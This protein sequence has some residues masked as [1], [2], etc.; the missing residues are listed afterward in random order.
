MYKI[1]Y[2]VLI[3][4]PLHMLFAEDFDLFTPEEK[5]DPGIYNNLKHHKFRA[6]YCAYPR[7]NERTGIGYEYFFTKKWALFTEGL[8]K[9]SITQFGNG[10]RIEANLGVTYRFTKRV[11]G[12]V[13]LGTIGMS[14]NNDYNNDNGD[15]RG[16]RIN[17]V[18][19]KFTAEYSFKNGF[20]VEYGLVGKMSI[21]P[22]LDENEA[23]HFLSLV[24]LF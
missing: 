24:Y 1:F 10:E 17:Q 12:P 23:H 14:L 22:E 2:L 3:L 11:V 15:N 7:T 4:L 16:F 13:F 6:T 21:E 19:V 5:V 18:F 9:N 20:G 8:Y